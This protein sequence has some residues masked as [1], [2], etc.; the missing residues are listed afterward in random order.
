MQI[1][2]NREPSTSPAVRAL[3][4]CALDELNRRYGANADDHSL[5]FEELD[6]P[7]GA[8]F[9]ARID[10]HLA[11]GV[12]LRTITDPADRVAEVT[13]LWV[14][15][16]LRKFGVAQRLMSELETWATEAGFLT[17]YLETGDRQPEAIAFYS[18]INYE[19]V[20]AFPE[21][22]EHYPEGL[23]FKKDLS[24]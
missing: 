9:V 19:R 21:G 24:A 20:T 16:D 18:R 5:H 7:N 8:F 1:Q 2:V 12:A 11:G 23:K 13:R 14:R 10:G 15:P 17:I 6:P 4:Y 3:V 22:A